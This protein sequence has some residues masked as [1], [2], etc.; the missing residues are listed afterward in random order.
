MRH[1]SQC[2]PFMSLPNHTGLVLLLSC[3]PHCSTPLKGRAWHQNPPCFLSPFSF[4]RS[5]RESPVRLPICAC[6]AVCPCHR[7]ILREGEGHVSPC[8]HLL[9]FGLS[10]QEQL[11]LEEPCDCRIN[12]KSVLFA[13]VIFWETTFPSILSK[14]I[15]YL[16]F[17]LWAEA[18]LAWAG[19][20]GSPLQLVTHLLGDIQASG[21][22]RLD[23]VPLIQ[24]E[25]AM[26]PQQVWK[27]S[28][29][30]KSSSTK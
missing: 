30:N 29:G 8:R 5:R 16:N 26:E 6:H 21:P 11:R 4:V 7:A 9:C 28:A 17:A 15:P 22:S 10:W 2:W 25:A 19:A 20:C 27:G 12:T 18:V 24:R 23:S 3:R 13:T 1:V 14:P